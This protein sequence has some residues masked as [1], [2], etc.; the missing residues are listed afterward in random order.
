MKT[1]E[2]K[3]TEKKE[4]KYLNFVLV[5]AAGFEPAFDVI[6]RT[7]YDC[8]AYKTTSLHSHKRFITEVTLP[9]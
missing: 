8:A 3:R 5:G 9:E 2:L 7:S 4:R 1:K 6:S